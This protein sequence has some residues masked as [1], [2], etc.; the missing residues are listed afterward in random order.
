MR[1]IFKQRLDVC[2]Q[3]TIQ[4]PQD[5]RILHMDIQRGEPCIWYECDTDKPLRLSLI[6]I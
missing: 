2:D 5:F 3:Q 4:L 1:T 6:H